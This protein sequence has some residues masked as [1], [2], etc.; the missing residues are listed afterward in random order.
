MAVAVRG[1]FRAQATRLINEERSKTRSKMKSR[2]WGLRLN[3]N[4]RPK[5]LHLDRPEKLYKDIDSSLEFPWARR[6]RHF[7]PG[8]GKRGKGAYIDCAGDRCLVCAYGDPRRFG[9]KFE[10]DKVLS[11]QDAEVYIGVS[12]WEEEWFHLVKQKKEGKKDEN[13]KV[14]TFMS[15]EPCEGKN[16]EHCAKKR[17]KV[18][19]QR[20]FCAFS[21]A[22]WR[23]L[24]SEIYEKVERICQCTDS[25]GNHGY[26][27][28]PAYIC[29]NPDCGEETDESF[30]PTVL[31]DMMLSCPH[32]GD[33]A[34]GEF[35]ILPNPENHTAVCQKC[36]M[37][38]SLLESQD[39]E[40]AQRVNQLVRC[41]VCGNEDY[42]KPLYVCTSEGCEG[43]PHDIYD[44]QMILRK[45]GTGKQ[46]KLVVVDWKI[47]PP[48][49][50]LF[51]PSK[52]GEG[53]GAENVT[54]RHRE[55]LD[56]DQI[57][58]PDP[59]SAQA[60]MLKRDNLFKDVGGQQNFRDYKGPRKNRDEES[61]G[62]EVLDDDDGGY[63]EDDASDE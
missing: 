16:C 38:W 27:Y 45:E 1:N 24:M 10:P 56:L 26:L 34:E 46:T 58:A 17:K 30:I 7:I 29:S 25:K 37:E 48:D 12:G 63:E 5:K 11:R 52:Q 35:E 2:F 60:E 57:F 4:E 62:D 59:P 33:A 9:F 21:D 43:M 6:R 49:P 8:G 55:H 28:L 19:G 39:N 50:R 53:E 23:T 42:P 61:S 15:R 40:L 36:Q 18:F 41:H 31:V 3:L 22:Q 47:Q 13:G 44:V 20:F 32:C 51:D 14:Q 54:K